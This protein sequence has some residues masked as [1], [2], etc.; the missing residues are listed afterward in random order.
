MNHF[1]DEVLKTEVNRLY[2][3]TNKTYDN[4]YET[5]IYDAS[6]IHAIDKYENETDAIIGHLRW[7]SIADK[8]KVVIKLGFG[9]TKDKLIHIQR[10]AV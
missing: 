8:L 9:S 5:S 3:W 6:G 7:C 4:F 10:F 2:V 1:K